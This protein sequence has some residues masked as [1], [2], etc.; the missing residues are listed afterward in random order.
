VKL[1]AVPVSY[2]PNPF[3][4]TMTKG[5]FL[6]APAAKPAAKAPAKKTG[7]GTRRRR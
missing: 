2:T 6:G 4:I 7:T 3:L 1:E 5:S